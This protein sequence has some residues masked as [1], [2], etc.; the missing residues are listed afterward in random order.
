MRDK[1]KVHDY[2]FMPEPNLPPLHIYDNKTLP[3]GEL[4]E[5]AVY[6]TRFSVLHDGTLVFKKARVPNSRM[7][8]CNQCLQMNYIV[9]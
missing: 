9:N 8:C 1:E 7:I 5:P 2:R 6:N 3:A 4:S